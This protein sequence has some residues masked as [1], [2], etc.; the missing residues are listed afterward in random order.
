MGTPINDEEPATLTEAETAQTAF[1]NAS[2][3]QYTRAMTSIDAL[4][5]A[6]ADAMIAVPGATEADVAVALSSMT[7][8]TFKAMLEPDLEHPLPLHLQAIFR[9]FL[10]QFVEQLQKL[11]DAF[12]ADLPRS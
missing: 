11:S 9:M 4:K 5:K 12:P 2:A 1:V 8:V 6:I 10:A 7:Y 3:E